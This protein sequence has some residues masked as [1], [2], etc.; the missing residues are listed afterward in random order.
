MLETRPGNS[1]QK[2]QNSGS[3]HGQSVSLSSS[4]SSDQQQADQPSSQRNS[5]RLRQCSAVGL[6][7]ASAVGQGSCKRAASPDVEVS[8]QNAFGVKTHHD[9]MFLC[10]D[11]GKAFNSHSPFADHIFKSEEHRRMT[12]REHFFAEDDDDF[13]PCFVCVCCCSVSLNPSQ[14]FDHLKCPS[15]VHNSLDQV[16]TWYENQ[17]YG[18]SKDRFE[19]EARH[20]RGIRKLERV[21][22]N[23]YYSDL[24]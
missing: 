18:L 4:S 2:G 23:V 24:K 10:T 13:T 17:P 7:Y 1:V 15:H 8:S 11:C 22:T 3:E 16:L 5:K 12:R 21:L 20:H 9:T 14:L 6:P 19:I